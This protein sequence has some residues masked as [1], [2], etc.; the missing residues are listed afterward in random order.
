MPAKILVVLKDAE[1]GLDEVEPRGLLA[2]IKERAAPV[3]VLD[4]MALKNTRNTPLTFDTAG[5][6]A[7][8]FALSEKTIPDLSASTISPPAGLN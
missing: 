1:S 4:A 2:T 5:T 6:L 8:Q 3:T 7:M